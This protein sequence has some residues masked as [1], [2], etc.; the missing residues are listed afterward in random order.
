M[1]LKRFFKIKSK[2]PNKLKIKELREAI[3]LYDTHGAIDMIYMGRRRS[4]INIYTNLSLKNS[5][6]SI[7]ESTDS[8]T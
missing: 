8:L 7:Y 5:I 4:I 1:R 3:M 6:N 2:H